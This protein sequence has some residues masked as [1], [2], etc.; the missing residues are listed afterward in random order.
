[1][2]DTTIASCKP[3]DVAGA[4]NEAARRDWGTCIAAFVMQRNE[5]VCEEAKFGRGE[6]EF[7]L[8]I[9]SQSVH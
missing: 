9:A 4:K 8:K 5:N 7:A 3:S 1:M 2:P 6:R